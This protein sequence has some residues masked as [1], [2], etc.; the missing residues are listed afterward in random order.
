MDEKI[1]ADALKISADYE[2]IV[3]LSVRQ[4]LGACEWTIGE[5]LD[6]SDIMGF[7]KGKADTVV[8]AYGT[9]SGV[10]DLIRWKCQYCVR[11]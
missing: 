9:Y 6:S 4:A 5:D 10:R 1:S 7:L 8:C 11:F 3:E 2:A